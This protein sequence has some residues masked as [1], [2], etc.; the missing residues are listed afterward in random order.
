MLPYDVKT[1]GGWLGLRCD[2]MGADHDDDSHRSR[3]IGS[4]DVRC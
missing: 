3:S 1:D 2:V 4:E